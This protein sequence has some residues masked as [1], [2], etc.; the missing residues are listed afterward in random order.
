MA[1][2]LGEALFAVGD[3]QGD[4]S[5]NAC[6]YGQRDFN[7]LQQ[8]RG[9]ENWRAFWQAEPCDSGTEDAT[10]NDHSTGKG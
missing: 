1:I 3:D 2:F 5:A 10:D 9:V 6:H 8:A 4:G 7:D